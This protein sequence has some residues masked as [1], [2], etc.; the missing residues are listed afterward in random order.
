MHCAPTLTT[1][2]SHKELH[3]DVVLLEGKHSVTIG[4]VGKHWV[5]LTKGR[6]DEI[7][8]KDADGLFRDLPGHLK[9]VDD[10]DSEVANDNR[11]NLI[12][13]RLCKD[14]DLDSHQGMLI[15]NLHRQQWLMRPE[16]KEFQ[17][18]AD[19]EILTSDVSF[20]LSISD[21]TRRGRGRGTRGGASARNCIAAEKFEDEDLDL[22][23]EHSDK[24]DK[25]S[26]SFADVADARETKIEVGLRS[27]PVMRDFDLNMELD[28]S[29]DVAST[30][31][32]VK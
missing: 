16:R 10:N 32:T 24:Q 15:A 7:E 25:A 12:S 3:G 18:R 26:E 1:E 20:D 22:S 5:K 14:L 21:T 29:G 17:H 11:V 30:Q 13:S 19:L 28:E 31:M 6:Y 8:K 9:L 4:R 27:I 23:P 2:H